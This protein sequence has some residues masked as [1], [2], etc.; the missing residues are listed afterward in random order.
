MG[1]ELRRRPDLRVVTDDNMVPEFK[2]V[3]G[4][5]GRY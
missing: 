1:D 5:I 4:K 2:S 3:R